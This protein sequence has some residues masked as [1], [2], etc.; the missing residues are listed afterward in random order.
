[1]RVSSREVWECASD[2]LEGLQ[3]VCS[4]TSDFVFVCCPI[5]VPVNFVFVRDFVCVK[6]K[7]SLSLRLKAGGDSQVDQRWACTRVI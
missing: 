4:Q 6:E 7:I 1:M 2:E 5:P 3:I